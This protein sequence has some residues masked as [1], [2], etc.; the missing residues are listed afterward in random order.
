MNADDNKADLGRVAKNWKEARYGARADQSCQSDK[1]DDG[2][3]KV[4]ERDGG[5]ENGKKVRAGS[6]AAE[7]DVAVT[8]V[9]PIETTVSATRIEITR[10]TVATSSA[11][12]AP[13]RRNRRPAWTGNPN[14]TG[15]K[16]RA[17][18]LSRISHARHSRTIPASIRRDCGEAVDEPRRFHEF[19]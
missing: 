10:A 2:G 5:E 6:T 17:T 14:P 18:S 19:G 1:T 12:V 8:R 4:K 7:R 15:S 13:R 16:L 9:M 3:A 11:S